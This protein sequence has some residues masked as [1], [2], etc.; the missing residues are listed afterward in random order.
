M[1][2][3]TSYSLAQLQAM[4]RPQLEQA[5]PQKHPLWLSRGY[6]CDIKAL[7]RACILAIKELHLPILDNSGCREK[8]YNP[9]KAILLV[10]DP[11]RV[12]NP[13]LK[14][15]Y[16]STFEALLSE[17]VKAGELTYA[18]L[19]VNDFRTLKNVFNDVPC[20]MCWTNV[21]LFV[22]KDA[23]YVHLEPLSKFFNVN[24]ISGGGWTHTAG[25]ER[26]LRELK[27]KGIS[28]V[29]VFGL[30]D[31]DPFAFAI[32]TEFVSTCEKLGL[33]VKEYHRIGISPNHATPAILD[34]QKYPVEKG[35]KR[36]LSVNG[37]NFDSDRWLEQYGIA[38]NGTIGN[39][40]YG[41]EIEA[42]SGQQGGHQ[43]LREIV[44]QELL[45]YLKE[46]DRVEELTA[47]AWR[48]VPLEAVRSFMYGIDD[49]I[50]TEQEIT[51]LPDDVPN[52][53]LTKREYDERYETIDDAEDE[54]TSEVDGEIS[55]L[56]DLL[57]EKE[58]EKEDIQQP[59]EE[60]KSALTKDY[61]ISAKLVMH[62]LYRYW[63]Q[64]QD[65][66]P[67]ER[68]S[69]G[70]S[71]GCLLEA[72]KQQGNIDLFKRHLNTDE[73]HKEI[74]ATFNEIVQNGEFTPLLN[75]TLQDA[76]KKIIDDHNAQKDADNDGD[77]E[78]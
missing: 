34:V 50:P 41:L 22:E 58:T 75:K 78:Q 18:D 52:E 27:Q 67:R 3:N 66:W 69:L 43:Q 44:A 57:E 25:I 48:E 7:L 76:A 17:M 39:G 68:Y 29:V 46:S 47:K 74:L 49:S 53:F 72:V 70:Y 2:T 45:K 38:E 65:K 20:A 9:I 51:T 24:I 37:I 28:E 15:G 62:T 42:V 73:P 40:I 16:M 12:N 23:A 6:K 30:G 33:H 63:Q 32:Q 64:H 60:K 1:S 56:E 13:N 21:L 36:K 11:E 10:A 31:Y 19:G 8:W 55:R 5:F 77:A 61:F 54:M 35:R 4:T 59:Y 71:E 14:Q 26:H